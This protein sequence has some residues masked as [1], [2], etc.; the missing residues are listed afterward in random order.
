MLARSRSEEADADL[1]LRHVAGRLLAL[2]DAVPAGLRATALQDGLDLL[3]VAAGFK[4]VGLFGRGFDD[5]DWLTGVA[6]IAQR[7]GLLSLTGTAWQPAE[8]PARFPAWYRQAASERATTV[9]YICRDP[10]TAARVRQRCAAGRV[11]VTD[12]AALLCYPACC[13]AQHHAQALALEDLSIALMFG[14]AGHDGAHLRRLVRAGVTPTPRS[15]E[16]WR[17]FDEATAIDPQPW[18]SVDR[19]VACA[20]DPDSPAE[21]LGRRYRTLAAALDYPNPT[22]R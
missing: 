4:P 15:A 12:E 6:A 22:A 18:T 9:L 7:L 20:A 10:Q 16:E 17:R 3:A 11:T 14:V 5:V 19:C 21:Q 8:P 2:A 13:V 1:T